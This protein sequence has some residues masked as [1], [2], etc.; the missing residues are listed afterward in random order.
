M[1]I[2]YGDSICIYSMINN[3][4]VRYHADKRSVKCD[5]IH[6]YLKVSPPHTDQLY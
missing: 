4:Y 6:P 1:N 2:E 3:M 5:S